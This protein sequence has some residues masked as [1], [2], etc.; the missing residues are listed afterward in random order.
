MRLL[1]SCLTLFLVS[2]ISAVQQAHAEQDH[3]HAAAP[4]LQPLINKANAYLTTGQFNDA[5]RAY[6]EA[7]GEFFNLF[8][9]K[10]GTRS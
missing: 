7:I 4:E 8:F 5:I 2:I 10:K 3:G 9:S 6:S 1:P